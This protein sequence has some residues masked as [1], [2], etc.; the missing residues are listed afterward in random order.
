MENIQVKAHQSGI[1]KTIEPYHKGNSQIFTNLTLKR[2]I[3]KINRLMGAIRIR[4][5]KTTA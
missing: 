1:K 2:T 5:L 3:M 4:S